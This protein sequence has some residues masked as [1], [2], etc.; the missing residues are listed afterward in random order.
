M[1][2]GTPSRTRLLTDRGD[3]DGSVSHPGT[4]VERVTETCS[5]PSPRAC[6]AA[7]TRRCSN[8][9]CSPTTSPATCSLR[10]STCPP[11]GWCSTS[12]LGMAARSTR[13]L[14]ELL[15]VVD[16]VAGPLAGNVLPSVGG[17]VRRPDV[18][19][20]ATPLVDHV[21][22]LVT[23]LG[24]TSNAPLAPV[25]QAVPTPS[26]PPP[27]RRR[28]PPSAGATGR[29]ARRRPSRARRPPSLLP[30]D[31][32]RRRSR[33]S[34]ARGGRA[35]RPG[36]ARSGCPS[37][38]STRPAL[39]PR[40]HPPWRGRARRRRPRCSAPDHG[41]WRVG[42]LAAARPFAGPRS[43]L[44]RASPPAAARD[45]ATSRPVA[46]GSGPLPKAPDLPASSAGSAGSAGSGVAFSLFLALLFSAAA[47]ALQ[48][49]SRLRLPP[50]QWRQFA[51]VAVIERPG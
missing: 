18:A 40:S 1:P 9:L 34:L 22:D 26:R 32:P 12:S 48:H 17:V 35:R 37:T 27:A 2:P 14:D 33:R 11:S 50:A 4:T 42:C 39:A 7:T 30:S 10:S 20:T 29:A 51:F 47:F 16:D 44:A 43:A 6:W 46:D 5:T 38:S 21:T 8:A 28:P 3:V 24:T 49:Y 36:R 25:T 13:R 15:P 23:P 31:A 45:A 41:A 19:E